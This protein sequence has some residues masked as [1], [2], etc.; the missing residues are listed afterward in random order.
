MVILYPH[1]MKPLLQSGAVPVIFFLQK[2]KSV[3]MIHVYTGNWV[4]SKCT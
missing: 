1:L 2:S 3:G 4:R